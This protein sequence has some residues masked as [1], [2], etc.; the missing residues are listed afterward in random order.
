MFQ[1][2]LIKGTLKVPAIQY[3]ISSAIQVSIISGFFIFFCYNL[4]SYNLYP[5]VIRTIFFLVL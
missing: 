4:Y 2:F 5:C 1:L 3:S